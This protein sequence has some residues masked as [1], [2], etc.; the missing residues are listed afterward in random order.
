MLNEIIKPQIQ[1]TVKSIHRQLRRYDALGAA[2]SIKKYGPNFW[3][4][5]ETKLS[6]LF[7]KDHE[8]VINCLVSAMQIHHQ[9]N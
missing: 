5:Y 3:V 7:P 4:D 8:F 9:H 2:R 6:E 1:Y